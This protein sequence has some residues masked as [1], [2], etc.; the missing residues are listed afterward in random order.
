MAGAEI[1]LAELR[2][3]VIEARNLVIKTDNLLKNLHAELKLTARKQEQFERR[4]LATSATALIIFALLATVGAYMYA[5]SEIHAV[6]TESSANEAQAKTRG[7]EVEKLRQADSARA[8]TSEKALR[9]FDQLS[10]DK[11]G[12][13]LDA[14]L[15]EAGK[16]DKSLMTP[17]EARAIEDKEAQLKSKVAQDCHDRGMRAFRNRDFRTAATELGRYVELMP[18]GPETPLANYWLGESRSQIRDFQG[19]VG[20][21]EAFMKASPGAKSLDWASV[22]LGVAYEETGQWAKA[23]DVYTKAIDKFPA[24]IHTPQMRARLKKVPAAQ[25]AAEA[26][27][28]TVAV[29]PKP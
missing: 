5:R 18:N 3:E 19:A 25:A 24:S 9:I 13:Q 26:K 15:I 4:H 10:S 27:K 29:P 2:K 23:A 14:A 22:L 16:L 7:Q 8:A 1:A 20:P 21:L 11:A 17:L 28:T 12:P 6:R